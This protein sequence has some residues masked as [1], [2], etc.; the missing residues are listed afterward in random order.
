MYKPVLEVFDAQL[1]PQVPFYPAGFAVEITLKHMDKATFGIVLVAIVVIGY[2]GYVTVLLGRSGTL[3]KWQ[4]I[5]QGA[6]VWLLPLLGAVICH[7][8]LRL[9]DAN[10]PPR[11]RGYREGN[12]YGAI[13]KGPVNDFIP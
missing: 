4:M 6:L 7:W 2:Q 3:S 12:P 8:F 11:E 1:I 9:H 5:T 10:E 13:E